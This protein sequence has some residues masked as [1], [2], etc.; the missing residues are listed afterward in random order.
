MLPN[1][2]PSQV[3]KLVGF[4]VPASVAAAATV[5]SGW[6]SCADVTWAKINAIVGAGGGTVALK[7]EQA[8][9]SS[10]T[11]VKDLL[12]AAQLSVTTLAAG[13]V[14]ADGNVPNH[15]DIQNGFGFMR[16][17]IVVTGGSGTVVAATLEVDNTYMS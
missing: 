17:N 13:M 15:I 2:V 6:V 1:Y 7:L 14:Q 16:L 4:V 5:T 12:T 9:D 10:G 3:F 11:G 8:Q